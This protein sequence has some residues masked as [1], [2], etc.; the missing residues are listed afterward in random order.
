[1]DVLLVLVGSIFNVVP[2]ILHTI[3]ETYSMYKVYIFQAL[4][5]VCVVSLI[6][7]LFLYIYD[8]IIC[9]IM[10]LVTLD[11]EQTL[12]QEHWISVLEKENKGPILHIELKWT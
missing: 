12:A 9:P 8:K 6:I 1:M 5:L 10:R 2:H 11:R 4:C 3:I 7:L